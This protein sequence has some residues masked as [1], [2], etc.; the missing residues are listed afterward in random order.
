MTTT[1][2]VVEQ[3]IAEALR[4]HMSGA[5]VLRVESRPVADESD[6]E[7]LRVAVVLDRHPIRE[8]GEWMVLEA[9]GAAQQALIKA[10]ETRFPVI[11]FLSEDELRQGDRDC[12]ASPWLQTWGER[13]FE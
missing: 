5:N 11:D 3:V 4:P 1:S 9:I 12:R 8:G 13:A 6:H 10:G 2:G 7:V